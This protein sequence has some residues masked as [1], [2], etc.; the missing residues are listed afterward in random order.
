MEAKYIFLDTNLFLFE[1]EDEGWIWMVDIYF[2]E[3]ELGQ[4]HFKEHQK[5]NYLK[6]TLFYCYI[7]KHRHF[8]YFVLIKAYAFPR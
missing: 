5:V 4:G 8:S 2:V 1:Q 3:L 6:M 7:N